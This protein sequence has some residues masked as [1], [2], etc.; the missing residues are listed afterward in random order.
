MKNC[1][2]ILLCVLAVLSTGLFAQNNT[3][4]GTVT[5][6]GSGEGVAYAGVLVK[7]GNTITG[8][9]SDENGQ[10]QITVPS[11]ATLI[12]SAIGFTE[13]EVAVDGRAVI[14]VQLA[15]DAEMLDETI[16]VAYGTAK[17]SSFT[18]SASTVSSEKLEK[19]TV[20]NVSNALSGSWT[21]FRMKVL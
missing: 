10:Y 19:R 3:V 6:A 12:F 15:E 2:L 5:D 1:K 21:V 20:S 13:K 11:N 14:D 7:G 8:T 16:V 18:G 9:T 4:K 17:K